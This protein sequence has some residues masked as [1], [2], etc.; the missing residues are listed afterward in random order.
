V[1]SHLIDA[2][3]L[4]P[5]EKQQVADEQKE[6]AASNSTTT[7]AQTAKNG[8]ND[9]SKDEQPTAEV[10]E[11]GEGEPAEADKKE[12]A[13]TEVNGIMYRPSCSRH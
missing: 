8:I 2:S 3:K 13:S 7:D 6:S 1:A 12:E 10:A 5:T 9:S 4:T 11:V